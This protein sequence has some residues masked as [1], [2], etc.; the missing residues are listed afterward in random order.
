MRGEEAGLDVVGPHQHLAG[1]HDESQTLVPEAVLLLYAAGLKSIDDAIE[2]QDESQEGGHRHYVPHPLR[3]M[4]LLTLGIEPLVLHLHQFLVGAQHGVDTV[5]L[6]Q[7]LRVVRHELVLAVGH[8]DR[9]DVEVVYLVLMDNPL[10]RQGVPDDLTFLVGTQLL[11]GTLDV[12][13]DNGIVSPPVVKHQ[14]VAQAVVVDNDAVLAQVLEVIDFHRL[15]LGGCHTLGKQRD[16]VL[17]ILAVLVVIA[18]RQRHRQ[19][20]TPVTQVVE[21]F[22]A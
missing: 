6:G 22:L 4:V 15:A 10:Q 1:L 11:D 21:G 2:Q 13:G 18:R 3:H 17:T 9:R 14:V 20:R 7:Q 16:G 5:N 8:V 19:V 12:L